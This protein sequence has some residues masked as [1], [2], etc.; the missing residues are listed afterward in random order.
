[1]RLAPL[2]LLMASSVALLELI[3]ST[4]LTAGD[5]LGALA[6]SGLPICQPSQ[7]IPK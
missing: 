1:M 3:A 4:M 5:P 2:A 7:V 6:P